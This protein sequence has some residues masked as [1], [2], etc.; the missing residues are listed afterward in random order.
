MEDGAE[1]KE[2]G[3]ENLDTG[4]HHKFVNSQIHHFV[5]CVL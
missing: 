5:C 1:D 4:M 2:E 3:K